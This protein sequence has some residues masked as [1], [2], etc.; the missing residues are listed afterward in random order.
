[1]YSS[2]LT[3][4]RR[5][6]QRGSCAAVSRRLGSRSTRRSQWFFTLGM[7]AVTRGSMLFVVLS[8]G[9]AEISWPIAK[10]WLTHSL[11]FIGSIKAGLHKENYVVQAPL[12]QFK[13]LSRSSS[14]IQATSRR[15]HGRCQAEATCDDA[16]E[17]SVGSLG[18]AG[19]GSAP[20]LQGAWSTHLRAGI[21]R[22][23]GRAGCRL[24]ASYHVPP[25]SSRQMM[26]RPVSEPAPLD[27]LQVSPQVYSSAPTFESTLLSPIGLA[28]YWTATSFSCV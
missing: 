13:D 3:R 14:R 10:G 22:G 9:G 2:W 27:P 17:L 6:R 4:G 15:C 28:S 26:P 18:D 8:Q 25:M 21:G 12:G 19:W 11:V 20:G 7:G 1:M 23:R 16:P 24:A 5:W